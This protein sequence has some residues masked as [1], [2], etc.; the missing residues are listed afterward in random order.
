[1]KDLES[2]YRGLTTA[3]EEFDRLCTELDELKKSKIDPNDK[4]L[5]ILKE[6][7]VNNQNKIREINETLKKMQD[8]N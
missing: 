4:K 8:K 3:E 7:F 6:K 5:L 1:M 2:L